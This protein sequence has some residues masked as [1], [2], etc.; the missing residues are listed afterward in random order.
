MRRSMRRCHAHEKAILFGQQ[1]RLREHYTLGHGFVR[2]TLERL[3]KHLVLSADPECEFNLFYCTYAEHFYALRRIPTSAPT[4]P[5]QYRANPGITRALCA[6]R[7]PAFSPRGAPGF[8]T[9]GAGR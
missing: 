1:N 3:N 7:K 6:A 8:P 9:A 2:A 5:A 4:P